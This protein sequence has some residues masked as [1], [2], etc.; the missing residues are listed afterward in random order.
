LVTVCNFAG[1]SCGGSSL[2]N[3]G[4]CAPS[5]GVGSRA[6]PSAGDRDK[7]LW[8]ARPCNDFCCVTA[9]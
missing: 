9:R 6:K 2:T 4:D 1:I 7:T 3:P 8:N 5:G